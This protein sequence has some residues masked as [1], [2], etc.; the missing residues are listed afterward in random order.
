LARSS[1]GSVNVKDGLAI[2]A[3]SQD[4]HAYYLVGAVHGQ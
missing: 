3:R 1:K 2:F 4:S